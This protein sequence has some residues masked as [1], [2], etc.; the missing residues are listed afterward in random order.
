KIYAI[1]AKN[2]ELAA[3]AA[4]NRAR[5]DERARY[6]NARGQQ[7]V[8]HASDPRAKKVSREM[9]DETAHLIREY[10]TNAERMRARAN[11]VSSPAMRAQFEQIAR[12]LDHLADQEEVRVTGDRTERTRSTTA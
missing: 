10:R 1:Q 7:V 12:E 4:E 3:D 2:R 6:P 9:N 5:S 11:S 8:R